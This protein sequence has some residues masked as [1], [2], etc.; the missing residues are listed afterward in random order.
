MV[1]SVKMSYN[2]ILVSE[3]KADNEPAALEGPVVQP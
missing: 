2:T 1:K 3:L